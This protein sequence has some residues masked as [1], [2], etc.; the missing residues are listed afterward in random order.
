MV[1]RADR[2][3]ASLDDLR[4]GRLAYQRRQWDDAYRF[5]VD[6]DATT[7][8]VPV[9]LDLLA[10][11]AA[12]T[13]RDDEL[14]TLLDRLYHAHVAA[15]DLLPAARAAFWLGFRLFSLNEVGRAT[16]WFGRCQDLVDQS[17]QD[18]AEQG[19]LM[20]PAI[21]RAMMAGDHAAALNAATAAS[22]IGERFH[23][24][25]L[26]N[27]ARMLQGRAQTR[28][29]RVDTGLALLDQAM[30]SAI[31]GE[32]SPLVTGLIYCS[33]IESCQEVYAFD[34]CREW[35]A[36]LA[37][38]CDDQPQ[39][40]T[41]SGTCLVH[42]AEIMQ[43]NGDWSDA[44]EEARRAASRLSPAVDP[45]ATASAFYQQAEIHRLRGELDAAEAA[46]HKVGQAGGEAQ[47][48]LALLRLAQKRAD[49][50]A[51]AIRRVLAATT[52]RLRRARFLPAYVEI[53]LT[54]SSIDEARDASRELAGI[55][56]DYRTAVLAALADRAD[57]AVRLAAGDAAGALG[58]LRRA[59]VVWHRF[60]A[61]YLA[62]Q[63]RVLIATACRVLGDEDG[64]QLELNAARD[65]F[66]QLGAAPDLARLDTLALRAVPEASGGL[67]ARELQVL[68]LVAAG[69]T[70][71]VIAKELS[72]SDRTV[73]R[74]VSNI[75]VKIDVSSRAAA[76]A[77]AYKHGLMNG[78][79][80]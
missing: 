48:G 8:L 53:M 32:V 41:F 9:D 55:A 70:N 61:P 74:H 25:D 14:L 58:P 76:A 44:V 56:A 34:R 13:G 33:V 38:W 46:Y 24:A 31:A 49:T 62:A 57:G 37:N 12:L 16:A 2:Q 5:L 50:A 15:G 21:H 52:S 1:T 30:L 51:S 80:G 7:P 35:T 42:R 75:F 18:C 39:L 60:G 40:V 20:L 4:R 65:I 79:R 78:H 63:L 19:Y 47:P 77:Y 17:G 67:T 73:D 54:I 59:F 3:T 26:T 22:T 72:V 68:R 10:W 71:K 45:E 43:L 11:S 27:F 69:K 64:A 36:V 28:L 29:G 23:D 6:A 66:G